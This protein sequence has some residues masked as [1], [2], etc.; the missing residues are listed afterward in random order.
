MSDNISSMSYPTFTHEELIVDWFRRSQK[1]NV[2]SFTLFDQF[3][4][5]WF[6]FNSWGTYLSKKDKD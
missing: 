4:A 1:Q 5:L 6:A 3:V 2:R